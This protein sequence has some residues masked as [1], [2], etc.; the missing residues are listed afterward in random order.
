M[1]GILT[2]TAAMWRKL[3][4]KINNM[5]ETGEN[6]EKGRQPFDITFHREHTINKTTCDSLEIVI[7]NTT[8][9]VPRETCHSELRCWPL[10]ILETG[11]FSWLLLSLASVWSREEQM[12]L[13]TAKTLVYVTRTEV[14]DTVH[15]K[16]YYGWMCHTPSAQSITHLVGQQFDIM[17]MQNTISDWQM[18]PCDFL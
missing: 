13:N 16:S 4:K 18:K 14:V 15:G 10:E 5:S 3:Q 7:I 6:K 12:R 2:R 8:V 9:S 1:L 11:L 17:T